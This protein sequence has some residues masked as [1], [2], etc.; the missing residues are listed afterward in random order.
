MMAQN[1]VESRSRARLAPGY[2]RRVWHGVCLVALVG[3][4]VGIMK[5]SAEDLRAQ[6]RVAGADGTVAAQYGV[7]R[8]PYPFTVGG[9]IETIMSR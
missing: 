3:A 4:G 7:T 9:G 1:L 5:S 8:P 6:L 2:G